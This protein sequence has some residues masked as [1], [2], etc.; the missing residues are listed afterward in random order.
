MPADNRQHIEIHKVD[1]TGS[2]TQSCATQHATYVYSRGIG[3]RQGC[4]SN[5]RVGAIGENAL[6]NVF[7]DRQLKTT[8]AVH[9]KI[10]ATSKDYSHDDLDMK[11]C[12]YFFKKTMQNY[13]HFSRRESK[14][15]NE[16]TK[17][18]I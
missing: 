1:R 18:K 6:R 9:S 3:C 17:Q 5:I 16:I 13:T 8:K 4:D 2:A 11:H 10:E 7:K 14:T 12:R 15:T